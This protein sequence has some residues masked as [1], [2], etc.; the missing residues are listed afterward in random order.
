MKRILLIIVG[1][2]IIGSIVGNISTQYAT[3]KEARKQNWKI[4]KE[5]LKLTE[6]NKVLEK[7]IEYSTS[8]AFIDQEAHDKLGLGRE[9]DVWLKLKPEENIDLFPKVNEVEETPKIRQWI[10]LFT[11]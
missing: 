4:E 5:I 7:K 3:L 2:V 1:L 6:E 9:N 10:R 11:Q 8:S